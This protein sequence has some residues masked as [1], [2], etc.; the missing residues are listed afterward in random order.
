MVCRK[1]ETVERREVTTGS[2]DETSI[3]VV[4]GLAEGEEVLLGDS[5]DR[6]LKEQE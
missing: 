4:S 2:R 5:A 6:A 3:E 1:G